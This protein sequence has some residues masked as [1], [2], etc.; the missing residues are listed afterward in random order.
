MIL[1]LVPWT[2]ETTEDGETI[3]KYFSHIFETKLQFDLHSNDSNL[4]VLNASYLLT[5]KPFTHED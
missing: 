4:Q 1:G 2:L 5:K 3:Q